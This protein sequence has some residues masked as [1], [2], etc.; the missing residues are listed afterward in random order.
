MNNSPGYTGSVDYEARIF[1][2]LWPSNKREN[3]DRL[4]STISD[5]PAL[6][7][8]IFEFW[9]EM[10]PLPKATRKLLKNFIALCRAE[11]EVIPNIV[12]LF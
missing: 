11:P 3:L 6:S 10:S 7:L 8:Q 4:L 1:K 12:R 5:D 9:Q 2:T